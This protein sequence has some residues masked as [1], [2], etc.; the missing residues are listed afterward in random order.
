MRALYD[1]AQRDE[2]LRHWFR[3][4]DEYMREVL[5]QP[6]YV[7]DEQSSERARELREN[8]RQFY[9]GKY[10]PHFDNL[11]NTVQDWFK[12]WADDSL[13]QRYVFRIVTPPNQ[14]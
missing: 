13:N 1:D 6:G 7:L 3:D 11:F 10:K 8:G 9:D 12:A 4:V 14:C 5:L 2:R